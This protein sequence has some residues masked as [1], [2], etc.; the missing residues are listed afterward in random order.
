MEAGGATNCRC[1]ALRGA[2]TSDENLP[3]T[4]HGDRTPVGVDEPIP[5]PG[6]APHQWRPTDVDPQAEKRAERQVA[7]LFGLATVCAVLFVVSYF[8]FEIGADH[9]HHRR[10]RRLQ[11]DA[12]RHPRHGAA[13]HRHRPDPVGPQADGRPRDRRDAAPRLVP[14]E[15]RAATVGLAT[16]LEESGIARR[17]LVR[18]SLLGAVGLL[19]LLPVVMLRDLG[20]LPGDRLDHT[21]WDRTVDP[22]SRRGGRPEA[23]LMRVVRDVVG[24]PIRSPTW[25]S[26]TWSTPSPRSSS[27][28]TTTASRSSRDASSR[29]PSPRPPWCWPGWIPTTSPSAQTLQ[30][31]G[32]RHRLLLQDLHPRRLPDL[33]QRAHDPPP[34]LPVPP[35]DVRPRRLRPGDLRPRRPGTAAAAA[36]GGRRGLPGG[37]ERLHRTRRTELLGA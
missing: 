36:D 29:S 23:H 31:V 26:A 3:E 22:R 12:R 16:G 25:R 2:R 27:R 4:T 24:T 20:P 33:A 13:V 15:D 35:V 19:G 30:L 9:G 21:I 28:S 11:R 34:A 37:P 5:N 10:P 6:L 32:R 1:A 7:A 18:N 14:D 17:P 8:V